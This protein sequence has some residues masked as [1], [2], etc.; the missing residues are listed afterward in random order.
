MPT[1][2][3]RL[4]FINRSADTNNS[5]IV[6]FQKNVAADYDELAIAWRVIRECGHLDNHP[7][8]Y[9]MLFEVS[10]GDSYGNFTPRITA[11][12]GQSFEMVHNNSGDVMQLSRT[13]AASQNE[14]E[15]LNNLVTGSIDGNIF[16]DG[17]LLAAKTNM[18][19]GQKAVFQFHPILFIGAVSQITEGVVMNSA[20]IQQVNT[21]LPLFGVLSADI[22]MTGGG[23][24]SDSL[25]FSFT[26]ENVNK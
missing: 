7:F 5:S 1:D 6:I 4:N 24:G 8:I 14:V 9:P 18:A 12:D 19:P 13:P 23:S 10:G 11:E 21:E 16:K 15:I 22:V 2:S 17:K 26:L 20:I 3:I 25:P